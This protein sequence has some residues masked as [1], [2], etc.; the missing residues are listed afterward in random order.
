MIL[1]DKFTRSQ[2]F[3]DCSC[4]IIRQ[5]SWI[6]QP[7]A[8]W[9]SL[10]YLAPIY[11][12]NR[13]LPQKNQYTRLFNLCLVVLALSSLFCHASFIRL[14]VAMDFAGIGLV[15]GFFPLV[16]LVRGKHLYLTFALFFALQVIV[17]YELGKW[18]K[19]SL[20]ILIFLFALAE[21]VQSFGKNFLRAK[22]LLIS[23]LFLT[24]SFL[25]FLLD[26]QKIFFCDE[27]GWLAGHTLWHY[28]TAASTFYFARWRFI[29]ENFSLN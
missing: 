19:I 29:D 3:P 17:N 9:S 7:L 2:C 25:M 10:A 13:G 21:V 18:P 26:D 14:S 8:F 4:E 12:L 15:I 1:W 11:F 16:K 28:G 27:S 24:V 6:N 23:L 5:E 20:S 22:S